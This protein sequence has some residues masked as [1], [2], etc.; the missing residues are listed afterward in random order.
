MDQ[1]VLVLLTDDEIV[2]ALA[3]LQSGWRYDSG[4]L[5]KTF[6]FDSFSEA[7]DFVAALGE[8]SDDMEG[9]HPHQV[10][11]RGASVELHLETHT[12]QGVSQADLDLAQVCDAIVEDA[13][14]SSV[15]DRYL[16]ED[17]ADFDE[18]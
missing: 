2:E 13:V 7:T 9:H 16:D 12:V 15:A 14:A 6:S 8:V 5:H 18:E 10:V 3:E 17:E 11:L 1:D 4:S